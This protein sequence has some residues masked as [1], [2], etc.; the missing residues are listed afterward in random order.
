MEIHLRQVN[1]TTYV[2]VLN[3][4]KGKDIHNL[5]IDINTGNISIL[6]KG[7]GLGYSSLPTRIEV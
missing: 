5:V 7:N 4:L 2:K 6:L 1:P 3:E